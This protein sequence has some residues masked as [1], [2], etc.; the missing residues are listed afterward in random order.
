MSKP[1]MRRES[2]CRSKMW[3]VDEIEPFHRWQPLELAQKI[4]DVEYV[5]RDDADVHG[6]G[7][8]QFTGKGA[9]IYAIYVWDVVLLAL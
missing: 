8:A 1:S 4:F 2:G 5:V 9:G 3:T 7:T 6:T